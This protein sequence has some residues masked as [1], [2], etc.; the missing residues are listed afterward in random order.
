VQRFEVQIQL[1]QGGEKLRAR[2]TLNSR[3][4][5][6]PRLTEP[7]YERRAGLLNRRLR[8]PHAIVRFERHAQDRHASNVLD[9]VLR[10]K[11]PPKAGSLR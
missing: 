6:R 7:V 1:P 5:V 4:R 2:V 10:H 8:T 11:L 9:A 3:E